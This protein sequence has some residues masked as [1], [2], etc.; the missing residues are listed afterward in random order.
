MYVTAAAQDATAS[1]ATPH[2]SAAIRFSKT[3]SVGFV[4]RP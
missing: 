3:S 4:R 2:S 1:A